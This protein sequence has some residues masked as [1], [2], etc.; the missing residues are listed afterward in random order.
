MVEQMIANI[1]AQVAALGWYGNL[2]VGSASKVF[3]TAVGEKEAFLYLSR[4][5]GEP[6]LILS[7][8]YQSE[9]RNVLGADS[10]LIPIAASEDE[11]WV[12][13]EQC[14]GRIEKSIADSYAVRLVRNLVLHKG[15]K[16]GSYE[17]ASMELADLKQDPS[18]SFA[19]VDDTGR[20]C[21]SFRNSAK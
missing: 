11:V 6:L 17:E 21:I 10:A 4:A 13:V 18:V 19:F 16:H 20:R 14:L 7:G 15:E 12:L 3:W 2:G 8:D 1:T 9:G 5:S